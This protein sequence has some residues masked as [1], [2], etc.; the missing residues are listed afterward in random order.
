MLQFIAAIPNGKTATNQF[1]GLHSYIY[2]FL[3]LY[4]H[5]FLYKVKQFLLTLTLTHTIQYL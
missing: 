4:Q 3:T 5:H 2:L 1:Q